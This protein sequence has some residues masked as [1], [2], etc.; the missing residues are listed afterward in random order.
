M[1]TREEELREERLAK[2]NRMRSRGVD[3][4]P[5]RYHRTHTAAA[6]E[7]AYEIASALPQ[8]LFGVEQQPQQP[9]Q[10]T[11]EEEG[12]LTGLGLAALE[13]KHVSQS[14]LLGWFTPNV[15]SDSGTW[16]EIAREQVPPIIRS[17]RSKLTRA[18]SPQ[19]IKTVPKGYRL[20]TRPSFSRSDV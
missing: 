14:D 16:D 17:L 3:P 19:S 9:L 13:D 5:P 11:E 20:R 15:D 10:L 1:P 12:V 7:A 6:A 2:L 4:Y 18:G 8:I